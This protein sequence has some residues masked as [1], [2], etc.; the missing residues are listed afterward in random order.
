MTD[1]FLTGIVERSYQ[2]ARSGECAGVAD[3]RR[4]LRAEGHADATA[5]LTASPLLRKDLT[6]LC[7]QAQGGFEAVQ[8][9]RLRG[10]RNQ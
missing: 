5:Q 6:R 9:G 8:A 3:I 4:R 7:L 1:R 2:L 10:L